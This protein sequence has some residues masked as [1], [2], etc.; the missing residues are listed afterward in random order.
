MV[1][2]GHP[3][4]PVV[5]AAGVVTV[6]GLVSIASAQDG[7]LDGRGGKSLRVTVGQSLQY[8]DNIN[9]V[10]DPASDV[11]RSSTRVG[12]SYSDITRTQALRISTGG[13]Y[14]I[15]SNGDSDLSDPFVRMTYALAGANSR[16]NFSGNYIRTNLNDAFATVPLVDIV[17]DI[18]SETARIESGVRVNTAY[19]F[20]FETGLQ[21]NIGF[22]L[23]MSAQDRRYSD[24]TDPD[25]FETETRRINV[26][27][28]FRI[29]PQVTARLTGSIRRYKADD[30]DQTDRTDTT[31][32][33]GV[34][35]NLTPITSLDLSLG[36]QRIETERLTGTTVNDGLTYGASL[37][38][39][40]PNGEIVAD[41]SSA[42]T[43][44]GRRDTL[45][46]NRST[47]LRRDGTLSYGI[48]VTK[49]AGF[50]SEPLFTL[51]YT[52]PLRQG[53]FS[54]NLSQEARTDEEDDEAVIL[55]RLSAN[56]AV[57]LT[58]TINWSVT[59][60]LNDV[61][62]RA[63]TGEDRRRIDLRSEIAG[64]INDVSSWSLGATYTDTRTEVSAAAERERRY[65]IALAYRRDLAQDWDIVARYR[66]TT[67]LDTDAADRRSN[68]IS[69]GLEK[70][71]N[72]KP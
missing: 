5:L 34:A 41:F 57:P 25:L 36:K 23:N 49:T 63:T 7:A 1:G 46:V 32:G 29:D 13:S 47:S 51:A 59:A 6:A 12:L 71:F 30:D 24:T 43:L 39:S 62:A 19:T 2:K 16:L 31:F 72:F 11:F 40:V 18:V 9:L 61:A 4:R 56:Y 21:S 27:T 45:R 53:R 10:A 15:D 48:G 58:E 3:V 52:Q 22:R 42:P 44:N 26:L 37:T 50:S 33:A 35:F 28:T 66:H 55:T 69:L 68:A 54:V 20:G 67:I 65:G 17:D 60:G 14:D 38:R 64:Q 8:S 70:T